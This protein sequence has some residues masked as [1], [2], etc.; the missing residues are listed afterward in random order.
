MSSEASSRTDPTRFFFW[1][2]IVV[3]SIAAL[4]ATARAWAKF[5]DVCGWIGSLSL[6]FFFA[7][8]RFKQPGEYVRE[9]S[10]N[11]RSLFSCLAALSVLITSI[12]FLIRTLK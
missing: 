11:P 1:T 3:G 10:T 8:L 7:F 5:N 9:Y 2:R 6:A 4:D 12:L